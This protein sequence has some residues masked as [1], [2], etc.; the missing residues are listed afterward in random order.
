M[1]EL[2]AP[3]QP[4]GLPATSHYVTDGRQAGLL[5]GAK[6]QT[7]LGVTGSGKTFR[8]VPKRGVMSNVN[9]PTSV[10]THHPRVVGQGAV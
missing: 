4:A 2:V 7:L 5:G 10:M 3:Y 9:K 8:L 1:L 6:H